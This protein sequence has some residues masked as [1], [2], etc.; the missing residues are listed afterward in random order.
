MLRVSE[1]IKEIRNRTHDEQET[2][3]T[4]ETLIS[5]INDGIRFIR[6]TIFSI[7][8]LLLADFLQQGELEISQRNI[9][10]SKLVID[11][12]GDEQE[13]PVKIARICSVRVDGREL[14]QVNPADIYDT[15]HTGKPEFYY[16]TGFSTV[17]LFPIPD[18]AYDYEIAAVEDISLLT[19]PDD[20]SPLPTEM[21]D[22][23]YEYATIR[24]SDTNEYDISQ[25]S[26]IFGQ[27]VAQIENMCYQLSPI[28]V[29]AND[30]WDSNYKTRDAY[31]RR[32]RYR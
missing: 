14:E 29:T 30:Y 24:A 22:W 15:K 5:Y 25:E 2:G 26:T 8:P 19:S 32:R 1:I 9:F 21:D 3:Y 18:I 28:G 20:I 6:R 12:I 23:L 7:N 4:D 13:Q 27:I 16:L 31:A 11:E 17:N 10:L